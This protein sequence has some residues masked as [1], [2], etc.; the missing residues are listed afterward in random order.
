MFIEPVLMAY[1]LWDIK[2]KLG[3]DGATFPGLPGLTPWGTIV[4]ADQNVPEVYRARGKDSVSVFVIKM[5]KML[6]WLLWLSYL[7]SYISKMLLRACDIHHCEKWDMKTLW[8][9]DEERIGGKKKSFKD[10]LNKQHC[11]RQTPRH[12][13]IHNSHSFL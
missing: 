9:S 2:A 7:S 6:L 4:W 10:Y 8:V 12:F 1:L 3:F 5:C 11:G 13:S